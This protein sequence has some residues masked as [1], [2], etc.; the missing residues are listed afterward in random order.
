V[1]AD[2]PV[3]STIGGELMTMFWK[4]VYYVLLKL[5]III[6]FLSQV[7]EAEGF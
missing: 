6:S 2:V 1:G 4:S 7:L 3:S 5:W